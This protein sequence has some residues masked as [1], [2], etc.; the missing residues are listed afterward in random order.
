[1]RRRNPFDELEELFER[2]SRQFEGGDWYTGGKPIS[3]DVADTG[4]TY[5]LTADLPG[6]D[7]DD[8]EL[9]L[10]EG[11]L[12]IEAVREEADEEREET[13]SVRYVRREREHA[14]ISRTIRL[15]EPIDEE[16]AVARYR[17]GVLTVTL[18]K[19]EPDEDATSIDIE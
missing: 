12:T 13:P 4:D 17:N 3:V 11:S 5:E 16:E 7:R 9:T 8:I 18:P 10:A 15:P 19:Q 2:M 14:E 1:M 6:Y